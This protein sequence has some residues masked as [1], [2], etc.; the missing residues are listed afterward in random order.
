MTDQP[1]S[2]GP[3][4]ARLTHTPIWSER[5]VAASA[6]LAAVVVLADGLFFR[7]EPGISLT[8]FFFA[9]IVGVVALQHRA[10]RGTRAWA[11]LIVAVLSA[12]PF[13]E[14][15]NLAWF[16]FALGATSLLALELSGSL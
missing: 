3:A 2:S 10:L 14:F 8:L 5:T 13:A 15:E 12:L 9:L 11:L 4:E 1:L 16:P 7:H 6:V